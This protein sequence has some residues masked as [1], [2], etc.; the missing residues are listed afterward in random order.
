MRE[1]IYHLHAILIHDGKADSGHYYAFIYDRHSKSW[2]KF[3][4]FTVSRVEEQ[5][6][7]DISF[8][9]KGEACAYGVIYVN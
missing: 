5:E 4:D 7:F 1:T 6:V 9:G 2:L 8:G 3:S